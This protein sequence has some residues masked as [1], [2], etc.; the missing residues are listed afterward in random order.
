VHDVRQFQLDRDAPDFLVRDD[1]EVLGAG[2]RGLLVRQHRA[3]ALGDAI[4]GELDN[5]DLIGEPGAHA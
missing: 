4:A 5:P 2:E 3:H 1:P